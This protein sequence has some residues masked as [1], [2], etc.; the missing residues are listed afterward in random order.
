MRV[1]V[2]ALLR[3]YFIKSLF[4]FPFII[5]IL[6]INYS[7]KVQGSSERR[8]VV[9]GGNVVIR[10]KKSENSWSEDEQTCAPLTNDRL[11]N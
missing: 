1:C 3:A 8:W 6:I 4:Q 11:T 7:C 10:M 2:C 9:M 5:I